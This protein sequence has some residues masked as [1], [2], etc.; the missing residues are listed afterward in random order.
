MHEGL[1]ADKRVEI[2][3]QKRIV[4]L[5]VLVVGQVSPIIL[6]VSKMR[7]G[8][9]VEHG[10]RVWEQEGVPHLAALL[11]IGATSTAL[12]V[13]WTGLIVQYRVS[14]ITFRQTVCK[15]IL[16][17]RLN[18]S[19]DRGHIQYA[20]VHCEVVQVLRQRA[21]RVWG[22]QEDGSVVLFVAATGIHELLS[23]VAD[24]GV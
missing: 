9:S 12:E 22:W 2:S 10:T 16:V 3:A 6:R 23:H 14:K 7:S 15:V 19:H 17:V 5:H 8:V 21:G 20:A 24:T 1:D 13:V 18:L 11:L 4:R